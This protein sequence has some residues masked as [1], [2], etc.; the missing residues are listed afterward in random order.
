LAGGTFSYALYDAA[1][2]VIVRATQTSPD[3]NNLLANTYT[4]RI[5]DRCGTVGTTTAIITNTI[6]ALTAAGAA[7]GTCTNGSNGVITASFTGG[8]LPVS[9]SLI[10]QATS[11]VIAGPQASEI[12][13]G[14]AQVLI[15]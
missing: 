7:T 3:V 5:I 9:Y 12:F 11:N 15:L 13:S 1:N 8:A 2:T 6:T 14:V 10:D 4:V